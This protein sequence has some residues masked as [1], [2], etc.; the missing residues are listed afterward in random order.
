M[1]CCTSLGGRL[2]NPGARGLPTSNP[3][4]YSQFEPGRS[5]RVY[6]PLSGPKCCVGYTPAD[7]GA[8]I[9]TKGGES[10]AA[11][12]GREKHR[13]LADKIAEKP[14]WEYEPKLVGADGKIHKPDVLTPSGRIIELKPRT[15]SGQAAGSRQVDRY[16]RQTGRR[17]RVVYYD[18]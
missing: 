14:G 17:G 16:Q 5:I 7:R 15:P 10:D 6:V 11:A 1:D 9:L 3:L 12:T 18:P 8:T 13:E 4:I 2:V